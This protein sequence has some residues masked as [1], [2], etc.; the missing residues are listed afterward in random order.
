MVLGLSTVSQ[1]MPWKMVYGDEVVRQNQVVRGDLF[2][3]GDTLEIDGVVQGDLVVFARSLKINGR[4]EGDVLGIVFDKMTVSGEVNGDLRV[5]ANQLTIE[6]IVAESATVAAIFMDTAPNSQIKAGLL[7]NFNEVKLAGAISGPVELTGYTLTIIGG[8]IDGNLKVKGAPLNW[9]KKVDISGNVDDY[10]GV[11][12]YQ[13][14]NQ[15]AKIDG[16]YRVHF[17]KEAMLDL[18]KS[19]LLISFVWFLGNLLI[20]L[21]FFRLFPRTAWE[22]T[23]PTMTLFRK[24]L[25]VGLL[26]FL[27]IPLLIFILGISIVGIP[28]AILLG[29]LYITMVFFSGVPLNI[30]A[31][32]LVFGRTGLQSRPVL[33][34]IIGS[35]LLSF[36]TWIPFL[37]YL[38][39]V[40]GFGMIAGNI[41]TQVSPI[42]KTDLLA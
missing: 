3:N 8:K 39:H 27:G 42:K 40:L 20:S 14:N 30:W 10:S 9:G 16:E 34:V 13:K 2:F 25:A 4:I 33:L 22:I 23:Q 41:K 35:V 26:G 11:T 21:I 7:G 32:R 15:K 19:L 29:L 18:L 1:A 24:N 38:I 6:G 12:N 5:L 17:E 37:G 28:L 36:F 31:G